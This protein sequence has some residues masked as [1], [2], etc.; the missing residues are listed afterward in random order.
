MVEVTQEAIADMTM[1]QLREAHRVIAERIAAVQ[2][3]DRAKAIEQARNIV[4]T[5]GIGL[6]DVFT[7]GQTPSKRGG[8]GK[9]APKYREPVSGVTWTGRGREPK[10]LV[11]KNRA[12][13]LIQP[14]AAAA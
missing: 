11:G 7:R 3:A 4:A 6:K 5:F 8:Q 1:P 2:A 10:W 14:E 12:D 13:F 9:V